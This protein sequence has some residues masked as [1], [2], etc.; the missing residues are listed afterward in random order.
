MDSKSQFDFIVIG[1]GPGGYVSAIR[2]AQFG[3]SVA[4]IELEPQLGGTC[5]RVGCIPSKALLESSAIYEVAQHH[6]ASRGIACENVSL[7]LPA[8]MDHK[9]G[10][11]KS[12]AGGVDGLFKKRK[13]TRILGRARLDGPGRVMVETANGP[14]SLSADYILI[15]T[16][17][18]PASLPGI[19]IDGDRVVSSTEALTFSEVPE[20]LV[21]IG[22]GYIGLELGTVWR[23]LGSEVIVLE[24]LERILPGMDSELAAEALKIF[25]KQGL[26]FR[27]GSKV[28]SVKADKKGCTIEVEGAEPVSC[29]RVLVAVGR[30]PNSQNLGLETV[31]V[32]TD[33][34][35]FITVD[36]GF[37]TTAPGVYAIGDVIGGAMLAHKAEEEGV[38]CIEHILT[39]HGHVNY[40]AIPGVVYTEPEIATVG[41][42]EEA[43]KEAGIAYKKGSFPF[44]GNARAKASGHTAGYVKI[45]ADEATDRILGVHIIGPHAGELIAEA[46]AAIEFGASSEDLARCC[47]AHPTLAEA[48]K[49]A[50]LAVRGRAIHI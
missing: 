5:L 4:C 27:L 31:G 41:K 49:E 48:M 32:Q 30:K 15:A 7:N 44:I 6:F 13:I 33:K 38:A 37:R 9:T 50:A 22:A 47:H 35:G 36:K 14:Q 25:R 42:T 45:L 26:E 8:M 24:F 3:K 46:T 28:K 1:G 29:D 19:E 39:G 11:V 2:A 12:L 18:L 20:R 10:V 17:S 43:C 40:G 23:R 34:R 16:G 21:V